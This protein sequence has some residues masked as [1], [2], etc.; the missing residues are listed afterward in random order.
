MSDPRLSLVFQGNPLQGEWQIVVGAS[1]EKNLQILWTRPHNA[2]EQL[3]EYLW[4][5]DMRAEY[6]RITGKAEFSPQ[7]IAINVVEMVASEDEQGCRQP[8]R[9]GNLVEGHAVYCH[10]EGWLYAPRKCRRTWYTDG[11]VRDEDCPGFRPTI[12][13]TRVATA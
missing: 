13:P 3:G 5:S 8:C 12:P 10:N 7:E 6:E 1:Y 2:E 4:P 9:F 11:K